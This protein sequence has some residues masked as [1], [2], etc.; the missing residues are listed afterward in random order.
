MNSNATTPAAYVAA[1]PSDRRAVVKKLRA[2]LRK[3]LPRGFDETMAYGM[4][5]WVVPHR[6]FPAG[7]HCDPA[8]PLPFI[9]LASQKQ[10]VSLYHM[11]LSGG[12]LLAWLKAEWPSHTEARLDLGK[13][14]LRFRRLDL[15]PYRLVGELAGRVTPAE[16]IETYQRTLAAQRG[17]AASR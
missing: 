6:L 9:A 15:I 10:Y 2:T 1:L 14:C 13:C 8:Q 4:L 3:N 5:A 17:V 7:Y 11:G 12:P 16:W